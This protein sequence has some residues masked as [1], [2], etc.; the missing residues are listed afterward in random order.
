MSDN[1]LSKFVFDKMGVPTYRKYL[2]LGS[3][4]HKLISGNMANVATPGYKAE[5]IDFQKEFL[6][7]TAQTNHVAGALTDKNHIPL[8]QHETKAPEVKRTRIEDGDMNSVD[9]DKEASTLAQNELLYTIGA[10]LLQKKFESLKTA[11]TSK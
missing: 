1:S 2:S 7:V 10:R 11:I 5:D 3:F 4:R 9:I 6:R 8:G